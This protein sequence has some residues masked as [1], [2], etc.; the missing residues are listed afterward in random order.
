MEQ[1]VRM[2]VLHT[3]IQILCSY[4]FNFYLYSVQTYLL[5]VNCQYTFYLYIVAGSGRVESA[6]AFA[7]LDWCMVGRGGLWWHSLKCLLSLALTQSVY[8]KVRRFWM[9]ESFE[10]QKVLKVRRFW[11][12]E[13]FE[14]Q[15]VIYKGLASLHRQEYFAVALAAWSCVYLSDYIYLNW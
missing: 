6:V 11:R 3:F 12:S 10:G 9:S 2:S 7:Y 8:M 5:W 4:I 15:K 1:C 14:G 13:S